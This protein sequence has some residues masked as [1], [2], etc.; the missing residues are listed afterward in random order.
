MPGWAVLTC[1][2]A[3]VPNVRMGTKCLCPYR[4]K[5]LPGVWHSS[6]ILVVEF[7]QYLGRSKSIHLEGP[8]IYSVAMRFCSIKGNLLP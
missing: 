7:V 8:I 5:D 1:S 6:A 4:Q 3:G 2:F